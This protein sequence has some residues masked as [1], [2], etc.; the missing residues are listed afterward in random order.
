MG[1]DK[2]TAMNRADCAREGAKRGTA[3]SGAAIGKEK[4]NVFV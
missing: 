2:N 3:G 4:L 1:G